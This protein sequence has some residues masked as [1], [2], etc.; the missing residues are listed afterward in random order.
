MTV[1]ENTGNRRIADLRVKLA[2]VKLEML[3]RFADMYGMPVATLAAFAIVEWMNGKE[4]QLKMNKLAV[5]SATQGMAKQ[6]AEQFNQIIDD[7]EFQKAALVAGS[8]MLDG[9][10]APGA[11]A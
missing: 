2:P 1:T 8:K 7:P 3:E 4:Q 11:E 9:E 5:I 10:G 6:Y